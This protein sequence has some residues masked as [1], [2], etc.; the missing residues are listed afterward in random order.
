M[1]GVRGVQEAAQRLRARG[2]THLIFPFTD[3]NYLVAHDPTGQHRVA[4][5]FFWQ[6]FRPACTREIYSDKEAALYEVTCP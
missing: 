1:Q 5:D 3:V 4:A 6:K 2:V